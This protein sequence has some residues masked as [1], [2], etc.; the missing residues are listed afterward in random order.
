MVMAIAIVVAS[1]L[2]QG[3]WT[4]RW[5]TSAELEDAASRLER[6]PLTIGEWQGSSVEYD[7]RVVGRFG[8]AGLVSR[9]YVNR[10]SGE[11]IVVL[12][13]CGRPGPIAAHGPEICYAGEGYEA[14]APPVKRGVGPKSFW[15]SDFQ[16]PGITGLKSLRVYWSWSST[17]EWVAAESPRLMFARSPVLYKLH[18]IRD[19][20]LSRDQV[21][22]ATCMEFA[23][24]FLRESRSL[25][26]PGR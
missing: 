26:F 14:V 18:L 23:G 25:L 19:T 13:V 12:V 10:K 17:G 16:K 1:G 9:R 5:S 21:P 8:F 11:E 15:M 7:H 6:I 3:H 2:V 20:T 24:E 4:N 22:D